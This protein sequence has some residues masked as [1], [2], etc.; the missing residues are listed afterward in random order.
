MNPPKIPLDIGLKKKYNP[1]P[2]TDKLI[3]ELLTASQK[4][5]QI[6]NDYHHINTIANKNPYIL[7]AIEAYKSYFK[8]KLQEKMAQEKILFLI[9]EHLEKLKNQIDCTSK[10]QLAHFNRKKNEIS[11]ELIVLQNDIEDYYKII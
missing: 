8:S 9:L 4:K 3:H 11:Q 2:E 1:L 5:S 7:K 10:E 6:Q